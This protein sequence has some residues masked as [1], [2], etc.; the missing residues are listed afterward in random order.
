MKIMISMRVEECAFY[1]LYDSCH[2]IDTSEREGQKANMRNENE[3][4][5]LL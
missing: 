4:N 1:G 2:G 5:D 3:G